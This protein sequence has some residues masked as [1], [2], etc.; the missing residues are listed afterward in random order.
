MLIKSNVNTTLSFN[1]GAKKILDLTQY[2][3][4]DF[5]KYLT[6]G[7]ANTVLTPSLSEPSLKKTGSRSLNKPE[8]DAFL[9]CEEMYYI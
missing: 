5:E 8:F 7:Q 9:I 4:L 2:Q 3:Y 6:S 1:A